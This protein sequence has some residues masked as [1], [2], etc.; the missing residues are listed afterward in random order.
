MAT[1]TCCQRNVAACTPLS[2]FK[3]R[4]SF[5]PTSFIVRDIEWGMWRP[6]CSTCSCAPVHRITTMV[7]T[8][9]P[10]TPPMAISLGMTAAEV[11]ARHGSDT[12]TGIIAGRGSILSTACS[13]TTDTIE[14]PHW[15]RKNLTNRDPSLIL[16]GC[17]HRS[18]EDRP[19]IFC[20]GPSTI[21]SIARWQ[22]SRPSESIRNPRQGIPTLGATRHS[23]SNPTPA[24]HSIR[25]N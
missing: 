21:S 4:P 18:V 19:M 6:C 17:R 1:G 23:N 22:G 12:T 7:T 13:A 14:L 5:N 16:S 15:T 20:Q 9:V 11:P 2:A 3:T 8:M 24:T 10:P 25:L